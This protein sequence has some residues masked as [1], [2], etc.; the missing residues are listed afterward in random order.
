MSDGPLPERPSL[1]RFLSTTPVVPGVMAVGVLAM[2][3]AGVVAL[4]PGL[5]AERF[6]GSAAVTGAMY[7]AVATGA[8][9]AALTSG[10]MTDLRRPGLVLLAAL[11]LAFS[12]Q[13]LFGLA[14]LLWLAIGL[15]LTVGF[16][17][18]AQEVLRYALIQRNTPGPLLGRVNGIWM[19]QEV[20]GVTVGAVVA[21]LIGSAWGASDAIVYYGI[22]MVGLSIAAALLLSG[23]RGTRGR[24]PAQVRGDVE[25]TSR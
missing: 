21:G 7:A 6:G 1:M 16:L 24:N 9:I 10:W 4:L 2:L 8:M 13:I 17:E 5:V 22:V 11:I 12:A 20:G 3:G 19:A 18:A 14:P 23:L 25:R 15:L